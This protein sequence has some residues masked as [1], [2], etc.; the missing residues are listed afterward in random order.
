MWLP[1]PEGWREEDV[2]F[3]NARNE[4]L[5]DAY[6][7]D[8]RKCLDRWN[9]VIAEHL[10]RSISCTSGANREAQLVL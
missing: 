3:R 1:G 9:R 10:C 2:P 5:R 4:V 7:A 8:Y 6:I